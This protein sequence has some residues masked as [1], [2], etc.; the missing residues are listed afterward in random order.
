[1]ELQFPASE[2][3]ALAGR[4][5]ADD[6]TRGVN[7]SHVEALVPTVRARG[8]LLREEM[9]LV[10]RWKSPRSA[11]RVLDNQEDWL[12]DITAIALSTPSE[13]LRIEVLTLL[14]GVGW[15]MASVVLHWFH[16]DEYPILD[17]RALS[18][19]GAPADQAYVYPFWKCYTDF[20]RAQA[21]QAGV[22]MRDLDRA[23]WRYSYESG[24]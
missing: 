7:D 17:Y 19:V 6:A 20:C 4:Y 22:T 9:H 24:S 13:R 10:A 3:P 23:L 21:G 16:E 11:P 18:S 5:V 1:M 8:Y 14:G 12:R 2:I 15:P